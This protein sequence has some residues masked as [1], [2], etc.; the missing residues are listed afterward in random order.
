MQFLRLLFLGIWSII[1]HVDIFFNLVLFL[2]NFA[3]SAQ[4]FWYVAV[5]LQN[6]TRNKGF[7][8]LSLIGHCALILEASYILFT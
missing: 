8:T 7:L 6:S 2:L 5:T 3:A 1:G 4:C